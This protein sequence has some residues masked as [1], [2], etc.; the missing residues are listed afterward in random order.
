MQFLEV[1]Q[2]IASHISWMMVITGLMHLGLFSV[3][4]IELPETH[5]L[6]KIGDPAL[7]IGLFPV[8]LL[9][10][11]TL[12]SYLVA[13][14]MGQR[15]PVD[16]W[17]LA[18]TALYTGSMALSGLSA[19]AQL[20]QKIPMSVFFCA[21]TGAITG[22]SIF[23]AASGL[24]LA[25]QG[26]FAGSI[27]LGLVMY[28][29]MFFITKPWEEMIKAIGGATGFSPVMLGNSMLATVLGVISGMGM[30]VL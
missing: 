9:Q 11:F 7:S 19:I 21:G 26:V 3:R 20:G 24:G 17:G 8:G 15:V 14:V 1:L 23:H 12:A 2:G 28:I 16:P 30:V 25:T 6:K 22:G 4:R 18:G 10:M 29:S 27:L 5:K 13:L